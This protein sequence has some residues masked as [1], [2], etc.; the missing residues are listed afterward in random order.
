MEKS[1]VA[2][3]I[4]WLWL[5]RVPT[6]VTVIGGVLAIGGVVLTTLSGNPFRLP[7]FWKAEPKVGCDTGTL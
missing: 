5:G 7:R 6:W 3:L 2:C 4:A 1:V